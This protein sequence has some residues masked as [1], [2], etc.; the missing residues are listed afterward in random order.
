MGN[1]RGWIHRGLLAAVVVALLTVGCSSNEAQNSETGSQGTPLTTQT[2][3]SPTSSTSLTDTTQPLNPPDEPAE[4]DDLAALQAVADSATAVSGMSFYLGTHMNFPNS[5][6]EV[7]ITNEGVF[8][9][10]NASGTGTRT[11]HS[12]LPSDG[13]FVLDFPYEFVSIGDTWW[14][15]DPDAYPPTWTGVSINDHAANPDFVPLRYVNGDMYFNELIAHAT[16]VNRVVN[17]AGGYR[18]WDVLVPADAVARILISDAPSPVLELL[19]TID[20][21]LVTKVVIEEHPDGYI[22]MMTGN[23]KKWLEYAVSSADSIDETTGDAEF[24]FFFSYEPVDSVET[25]EPPCTDP[26][27]STVDGDEVLKCVGW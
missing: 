27:S 12:A 5:E 21:G 15:S 4:T 19:P 23:L 20:S 1:G 24:T 11:F 26:T 18:T 16:K 22:T 17:H 6:A 2:A 13:D 3:P 25:P 8:D 9:D 14:F 10:D 7:H